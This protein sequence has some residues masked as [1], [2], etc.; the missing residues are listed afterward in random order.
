M[1]ALSATKIA[2]MSQSSHFNEI[3]N[4]M[5]IMALLLTIFSVGGSTHLFRYDYV[6]MHLVG[7]FAQI[8]K[9][10]YYKPQTATY[11]SA[12]LH[13]IYL[14]METFFN[15]LVVLEP[16]FGCDGFFKKMPTKKPQAFTYVAVAFGCFNFQ[17]IP[18]YSITP[19]IGKSYNL[20]SNVENETTLVKSSTDPS[21]STA[22]SGLVSAVYE[23]LIF[24][25][26]QRWEDVSNIPEGILPISEDL[27]TRALEWVKTGVG[28]K[29]KLDFVLVVS[30]S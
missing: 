22:P 10:Y 4:P 30:Y 19:T 20:N 6:S 24:N 18:K 9:N 21:P 29:I 13:Q 17:P 8:I 25:F 5:H 16:T 7:L 1:E 26:L 14:L 12:A 15:D 11:D 28:F 3:T 23:T 2:Q 27:I